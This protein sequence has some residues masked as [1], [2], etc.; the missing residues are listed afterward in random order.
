[1]L[2]LLENE[3]IIQAKSGDLVLYDGMVSSSGEVNS[4]LGI[5]HISPDTPGSGTRMICLMRN[6]P[7]V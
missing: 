1:M 6:F 3:P 7:N 5:P 4:S 2:N